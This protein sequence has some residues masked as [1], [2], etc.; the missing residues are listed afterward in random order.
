MVYRLSSTSKYQGS[1]RSL[2][3][4]LSVRRTCTL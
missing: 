3:A 2:G 1:R 4:Q